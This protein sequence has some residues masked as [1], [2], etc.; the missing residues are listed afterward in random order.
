MIF[1]CLVDHSSLSSFF[2]LES[3]KSI[4]HI[5]LLIF[6]KYFLFFIFFVILVHMPW[7]EINRI[8][9]GGDKMVLE[10]VIQILLSY[11]IM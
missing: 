3:P 2:K 11:S 6:K 9:W 7:G 4:E 1:E 8:G 10:E 5:L